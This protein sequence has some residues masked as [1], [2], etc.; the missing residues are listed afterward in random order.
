MPEPTDTPLSPQD[1]DLTMSLSGSGGA[2]QDEAGVPEGF[3]IGKYRVVRTV[4]RGGMG[5]VYEAKDTQ[6]MRPV[7]LKV[8]PQTMTRDERALKRF[9]REAQLAA[10][11]N[12]PNT[13]TVHDIGRK[14]ETYFI[15][16]ELVE[17]P[18]LDDVLKDTGPL[19]VQ[20]STR[21]IADCCKALAAAHTAGLIHRDIKP[22]NILLAPDRTVKVTDF[23][24]AKLHDAAQD[25]TIS[26]KHSLLGTPLYMSPEQCQSKP[27]DAR[28]DLYALGATY[29]TLLT[30]K[31]P[32]TGGNVMQVLYA[33][34][35]QPIP[36]PAESTVAILPPQCTQIV[37]KAMAK[38]ADDRYAS[39]GEMLR[40]LDEVLTTL[41]GTAAGPA[42]L[43]SDMNLIFDALG[44]TTPIS[45]AT[46]PMPTQWA[47]PAPTGRRGTRALTAASVAAAALVL[48]ALGI[49]VMLPTRDASSDPL[50][51]TPTVSPATTSATATTTATAT[52]PD[53]QLADTP[54]ASRNM[55]PLAA[56]AEPAPKAPVASAVTT[57]AVDSLTAEPAKPSNA[58]QAEPPDTAPAEP[59]AARSSAAPDNTDTPEPPATAPEP[60]AEAPPA[61]PTP[62]QRETEALSEPSLAAKQYASLVRD[63]EKASAQ[64][65]GTT[66]E[67]AIMAL[68]SFHRRYSQSTN[69]EHRILA[70]QALDVLEANRPTNAPGGGPPSSDRSNRPKPP[71]R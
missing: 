7:A 33:H 34:C 70:E 8:L 5:V 9:V 31:P 3:A 50:T 15:A 20:E 35:T 16:M 66:H 69:P 41:S 11:L 26:D 32:Y 68:Q 67:R 45:Q 52:T 38:R 63:L 39:A 56:V 48:I 14:G 55:T 57:A 22:A 36:D 40:D 54:R 49:A 62:R 51:A 42:S 30:G 47:S 29:Y 2:L 61:A 10:R 43:S 24:L 1:V 58:P 37:Q 44:D 53:T 25:P 60:V 18:S 27:V 71:R 17:G 59:R 12:H 13:V 21:I 6:L 23:G 28:T 46:P 4:G 64:G 65:R 19:S